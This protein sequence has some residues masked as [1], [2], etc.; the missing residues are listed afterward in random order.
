[1]EF[2]TDAGEHPLA[3]AR[4]LVVEGDV[5]EADALLEAGDWGCCWAVDDVALDLHDVVDA[6]AAGDGLLEDEVDLVQL[7][8]RVVHHQQHEQELEE[9]PEG[10][11]AVT[12]HQ[13]CGDDQDGAADRSR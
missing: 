12:D 8:D 9:R 4:V 5:V 7:A 10:Q 2:E 1:M 6:F 11:P 13:S 3:V